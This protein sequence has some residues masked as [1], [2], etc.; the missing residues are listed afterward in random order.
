[1]FVHDENLVGIVG[2]YIVYAV[3]ALAVYV[4][5]LFLPFHLTT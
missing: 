5:S 2:L 4:S 3:V 1:M